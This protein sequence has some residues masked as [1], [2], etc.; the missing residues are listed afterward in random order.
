MLGKQIIANKFKLGSQHKSKSTRCVMAKFPSWGVTFDVN[1]LNWLKLSFIYLTLLWVHFT[2]RKLWTKVE[3]LPR[4]VA[5][6]HTFRQQSSAGG[7][8]CGALPVQLQEG[9]SPSPVA[10]SPGVPSRLTNSV[11]YKHHAFSSSGR[12]WEKCKNVQKRKEWGEGN[13]WWPPPVGV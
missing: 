11:G 1:F 8:F 9:P 6:T 3:H 10:W 7:H 12:F 5:P 13:G 4:D 2:T